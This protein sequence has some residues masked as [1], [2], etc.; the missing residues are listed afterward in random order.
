MLRAVCLIIILLTCN[1]MQNLNIINH[2]NIIDCFSHASSINIYIDNE[3]TTFI[4]GS[5]EFINI[6]SALEMLTQDSHEM[7]AFSV[8]LDYETKKAIKDGVWL[9]LNYS[10]KQAV[11]E[12]PFSSL[13]IEVNENYYGFNLIRK[14]NGK[15]EGRCFYLN[16]NNKNMS[17]LHSY[18]ISL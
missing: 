14:Q 10:S 15:Y 7:P 11:N 8:S 6:L 16:L 3:K 13:L 17:A 9:E 1:Y 12:L 18:L 5:D 4:K 2:E